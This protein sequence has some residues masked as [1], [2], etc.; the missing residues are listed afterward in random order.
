MYNTESKYNGFLVNGEE[1]VC[2][3]GPLHLLKCVRN[4]LLTKNL[5]FT[6]K[7]QKQ[8]TASYDIQTL[9]TFYKANEV[10]KLRT[11]LK[12]TAHRKDKK[13]WVSIAVQVFSHQVAATM[14]LMFDYGKYKIIIILMQMLKQKYQIILIINKLFH[15]F[16]QYLPQ[17]TRP[18]AKGTANLCL[19]RDKVFD[20]VKDQQ[21]ILKIANF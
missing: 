15:I 6:W 2:I 11:L 14:K 4:N 20:S 21:Y 16:L 9:Y 12:L 13:M 17:N 1:I 10:H 7:C 18:G 19:F 3:Y 8:E 5:I